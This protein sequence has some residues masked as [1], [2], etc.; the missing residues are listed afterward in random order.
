MWS[1]YQFKVHFQDILRPIASALATRGVTANHVTCFALYTSILYGLVLCFDYRAFWIG[2]PAFLVFRMALNAIDGIM[3]REYGMKSHLGMALNEIGDVLSDV[4]LFIP[5]IF[6]A[7]HAA[8]VVAFF[9]YMAALNEMCG[10]VGY[11]MSGKRRYDGPM[12]KSDRA[13]ATGLLGFLIGLGVVSGKGIGA[14]FFLLSLLVIWSSINRIRGAIK[15][16][17]QSDDL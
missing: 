5:F 8:W 17:Q 16:G 4:A 11:M 6:F 15:D 12:G 9:I 2:L 7:P 13:L 10:V 1:V 14:V 3:A